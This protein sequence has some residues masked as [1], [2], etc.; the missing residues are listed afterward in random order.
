MFTGLSTSQRATTAT[1]TAVVLVAALTVVGARDNN[2]AVVVAVGAGVA[3][4]LGALLTMLLRAA[5]R[6]TVDRIAA[7]A[8][9]LAAGDFHPAPANTDPDAARAM[10]ALT[11]TQSALALLHLEMNRMG[12]QHELGDID[13]VID[14]QRF[15]GGFAVMAHGVNDLVQAH[16]R[17]KKQAMAVV[18]RFG[19]GDFDAPLEQFPGKKAFINDTIEEVRHNL[20]ALISDTSDLVA[21]AVAGRLDERADVGRHRGGFR[22]IVK[23]INDTLDAVIGPLNE[24][25]RVLTAMEQGDLTQSITQEYRGRLE[26]LRQATNNSM[27]RLGGTVGEVISATEQLNN[28]A[29]QISVASQSM[30]HAAVQQAAGVEETSAGVEQMAGSINQNSDNARVTDG[31]ASKAAAEASEGGAAVQQTV[32]AMKTIA[33]KIAIIDDIAFQTNMLALNATIEAARAGE[34]GKGFAVVA[35][36]VGKLAERSQVAAQEIGELASGSVQTAE[37]AGNLLSEIVP[38][39]GKTSDLVQE[40]AAASAEQASG[41]AQISSAMSQMSKITT[42]NAAA[43]EELAATAE[44]MTA[45]TAQLQQLMQFFRVN[46]GVRFGAFASV[47]AKLPPVPRAAQPAADFEDATFDRF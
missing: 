3:V 18:K 17:V 35:T 30:S 23:G 40:I 13:V 2:G 36:E 41:A 10:A 19:E 43:S 47:P 22:S 25:S 1:G 6:D 20:K 4:C 5:G 9:R 8:E 29:Q 38:S 34:H 14:A 15:T 37:R 21:A 39:I 27:A 33:S 28:A 7:E 24:V 44:E 31:I 46:A 11:R 32:R 12:E 16:I 26:L 45:Q 42:Q